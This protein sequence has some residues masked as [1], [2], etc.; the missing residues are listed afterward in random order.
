MENKQPKICSRCLKEM[1]GDRDFTSYCPDCYKGIIDDTDYGDEY[2][3]G[4]DD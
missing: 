4:E 3:Y 2:Y 1:D